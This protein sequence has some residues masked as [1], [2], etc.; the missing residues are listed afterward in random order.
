MLCNTSTWGVGG[1]WV[2]WTHPR[3]T[4]ATIFNKA[5]SLGAVQCLHMLVLPRSGSQG[6]GAALLRFFDPTVDLERHVGKGALWDGVLVAVADRE[7]DSSHHQLHHHSPATARLLAKV[8]CE[9]CAQHREL[10]NWFCQH[11]VHDAGGGGGRGGEPRV[12]ALTKRRCI[13]SRQET[14]MAAFGHSSSPCD[15]VQSGVVGIAN[16]CAL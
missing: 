15:L 12:A 4:A 2:L 5:C 11:H 16:L 10:L 1:W 9:G 8:V 6:R 7:R 14:A 13:A 3:A